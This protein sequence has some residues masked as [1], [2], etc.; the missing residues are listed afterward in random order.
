MKLRKEILLTFFILLSG[1]S[2]TKKAPLD[3]TNPQEV[4]ENIRSL[5]NELIDSNIDVLA[6][7]SF[8]KG[9]KEM[10]EAIKGINKKRPRQEVLDSLAKSKAYFLEAK[11]MAQTKM[12]VPE[13]I[14]DT[15]NEAVEIGLTNN[16]LK[17]KLSEVDDSLIYES[18]N[19]T[20]PLTPEKLSIIQKKY[21]QIQVESIQNSELGVYKQIIKA[22][23]NDNAKKLAPETL[24]D[25]KSKLNFAENLI[26]LNPKNPSYYMVS[27]DEA[28]QSVKLLD[29]VMLKLKKEAKGSTESTALSLVYQE[30]KLGKLSDEVYVLQSSLSE[31]NAEVEEMSG[32]LADKEGKLASTQNKIKFQDLMNE[33]RKSF[34]E[35]EANVYQQ[36]DNLIIRLKKVAFKSGSA[37]I[38]ANSMAL[39]SKVNS[40][41]T[42]LHPEEI[43]VEGHTDSAGPESNNMMLSN[44]RAEAVKKY[45]SSLNAP[46]K[47]DARGYG[48]SKPIANNQTKMGRALNRRVDIIV[49]AK[50][51]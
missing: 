30:R 28:R 42:K 9:D 19:F 32:D 44:K 36:G 4:V 23:E 37:T 34:N 45:L 5:K 13:N 18:H 43:E 7:S 27:V 31:T 3:S 38:P 25:A 1:C 41:I 24:R 20:K 29:D 33:V 14:M 26:G 22:A 6:K 46:Y 39:L 35:E 40:V 12:V 21:Q 11:K 50:Q 47:V 15:R 17:D 51:D 49:K 8:K 48:E 10:K 16:A 2:S